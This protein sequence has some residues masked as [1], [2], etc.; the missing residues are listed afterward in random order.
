MSE[1]EV[2]KKGGIFAGAIAA[3]GMAFAHGADDC[4]RLGARGASIGGGASLADDALRGAGRGASAFGDDALQGA[5]RGA[6]AFGD[7][8]LQ[9]A[10]RGASTLGDDAM[11][12][13]GHG[14]VVD[15]ELRGVTLMEESMGGTVSHSDEV[16]DELAHQGLE[17]AVDKLANA[18]AESDEG[19]E[20]AEGDESGT[21]ASPRNPTGG[22]KP[23]QI[24]V[25]VD[26]PALMPLVPTTAQA[27]ARVLGRAPARGELERLG[28]VINEPDGV[29]IRDDPGKQ[30]LFDALAKRGHSKP[31][32]IVGYVAKGA[33]AGKE[34]RLALPGGGEVEDADIHRSCV[35]Q[36]TSCVV[37]ACDPAGGAA[38]AWVAREVWLGAKQSVRTDGSTP[39]ASFTMRLLEERGRVKGGQAITISRLGLSLT[40]P[41]PRVVRSR[42]RPQSDARPANLKGK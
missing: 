28:R 32:G 26:G 42:I 21:P 20:G 41:T 4:A 7:D 31:I 3:L 10:G 6:S 25:F 36:G 24:G 1:G 27:Y 9:G 35:A 29:P 23:P 17:V 30:A 40:E 33:A 22:L 34:I 12:G 8:A 39:L 15:D 19:D 13:V 11:R 2:G 37:L 18:V 16:A 38:C 14:A 5:G